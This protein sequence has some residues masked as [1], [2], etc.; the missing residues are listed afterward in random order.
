MEPILDQ[1][2]FLQLYKEHIGLLVCCLQ[3]ELCPNFARRYLINLKQE[4]NM[5]IRLSC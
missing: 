4:N 3:L 2:S 1:K 5:P